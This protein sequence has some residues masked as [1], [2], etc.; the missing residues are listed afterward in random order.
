MIDI[1]NGR[2]KILLFAKKMY[3]KESEPARANNTKNI[4]NVLFTYYK[5][6]A[7]KCNV[8][9]IRCRYIDS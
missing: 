5:I 7:T 4:S 2:V 6:R 9:M 8:I 3:I 1:G